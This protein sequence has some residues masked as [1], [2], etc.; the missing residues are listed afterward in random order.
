ME[1]KVIGQPKEIHEIGCILAPE[2]NKFFTDKGHGLNDDLH[3]VVP[4]EIEC[5]APRELREYLAACGIYIGVA[6]EEMQINGRNVEYG[7]LFAVKQRTMM[8]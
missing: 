1:I 8:L 6:K 3:H 7:D 5:E 4:L 2:A